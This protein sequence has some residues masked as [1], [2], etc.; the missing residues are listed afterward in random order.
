MSVPHR[1]LSR[2]ISYRPSNYCLFFLIL[3]T[4]PAFG[5]S[6]ATVPLFPPRPRHI[7]SPS[8]ESQILQ[9]S[10]YSCISA[11]GI[12][13]LAAVQLQ[14]TL[15]LPRNL[16]CEWASS[17][18]Q[19]RT[20]TRSSTAPPCALPSNPLPN[21][22]WPSYSTADLSR[23]IRLQLLHTSLTWLLHCQRLAA[24]KAIAGRHVPAPV[25]N[26]ERKRCG[27][28]WYLR[29]DFF[30]AYLLGPALK[31]AARKRIPHWSCDGANTQSLAPSSHH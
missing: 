27:I 20:H 6:S 13:P 15:L 17:S 25:D 19:P 10:S 28:T 21:Q 26:V 14:S 5:D 2:S 23:A 22:T 29:K 11:S 3:S 24:E 31:F 4:S 18:S 9:P 8:E 30:Q 1:W 12:Y 16:S 7:A